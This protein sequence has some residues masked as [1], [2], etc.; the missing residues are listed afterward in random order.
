MRDD[1]LALLE[2][3]RRGDVRKYALLV[4][5]YKDRGLALALRI[6]RTREDAEEVLQDAFVRAYRG[7]SDFRGD[8]S[9]GTWFYRILYNLCL[10]RTRS[11][12]D[13]AQRLDDPVVEDLIADDGGEMDSLED[14]DL[15]RL[16]TTEVDRLPDVYRIPLTLFY[17]QDRTYDEIAGLTHQPLGTVKTNLHRAR[18]ILRKRVAEVLKNEG[19]M[20]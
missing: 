12:I 6:L 16:L 4:D 10:S 15:L 9:F 20:A 13:P 1:E 5:R 19:V 2:E 14:R 18:L 7:L 17:L 11:R 8:S 3:I